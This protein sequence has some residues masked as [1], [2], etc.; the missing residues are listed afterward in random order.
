MFW[1]SYPQFK[2]EYRVKKTQND[3]RT[4]IRISFTEYIDHL[5]RNE[6]IT[7]KQVNKI[8]L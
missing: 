4:D 8:T 1:Q 3:Y 7:E 5:Y 6:E 2:N